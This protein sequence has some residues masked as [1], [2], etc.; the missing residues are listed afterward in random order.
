MKKYLFSL[1]FLSLSYVGFAQKGISYQAVILDPN[2]IEAPGV[3]IN[4]QP[5]INGD[6]WVKFSIY[7]SALQFEEVHKTKTDAY[8]LVNLMIGSV[9]ATSFNSLVWD[10]AQK[11][12]QVHVSFDQGVSYTKVS[13]QKLTY[14]PYS[15]YAETAS[16]LGGTL[17]I[18]GG[19][20]GATTLADA[21][22]NLGID[23]VDNTPDAAKPISA[24]MQA[25]LDLKANSGDV[26]TALTLKANTSDVNAGLALKADAADVN[27]S[28]AT[29]VDKEN[30]KGLSSNDYTT[31]EKNKLAA[32]SGIG[33]GSQGTTGPQGIQGLTGQPGAA[34]PQGP[35]GLTGP[36]GPAGNDGAAGASGTTGAT[37]AAGPTGLTGPAGATGPQGI[38]G[39][40]GPTGPTGNDGAAGPTGTTGAT[41]AA[42]PTGATGLTGPAGATGPQG[43]QGLT[44]A[45][46][47]QGIQGQT[48]ATG[49]APSGTGIVT[50]SNGTLQTP[51]ELTGDI[52]TSGAGL[53]T[54]IATGAVTS[55]KLLDGTIATADVA[56][57]AITD[58]KIDGV[59]GTKVSGNISGNEANVSGTVA[60]ANGGTGQT[61][62][63]GIQAVLGLAGTKVAIGADAGKTNQ[64]EGAF[65]FGGA[66][67][68]T[69]QGA[70][71]V[72]LGYVAGGS[73][74]GTRS[75]AIGVNAAQYTQGA[76]AVAIGDVAG[77][78]SQGSNSVA[79]GTNSST[80]ANAVAIGGYA[81]SSF[82][83]S[84]A[85]GYK[86][87]TTA[88]NTIQLGGDGVVTGSTAITNVK[89]TGTL[90]AGTV[91]YPNTH[92]STAGQVLTINSGGTATWS[93]PANS[94]GGVHTVGEN[95]GGGIVFYITAGGL[96]GLIADTYENGSASN[97]EALDI[98]TNPMYHNSTYGGNLYT[99]WRVP[100]YYE[101]TL[102]Y[103]A[104]ATANLNLT[105]GTYLSCTF[106][107]YSQY[108]NLKF[109]DKSI[110]LENA[111]W[112]PRTLRAI[113]SF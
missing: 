34:G 33:S 48:G 13:D 112:V 44:G 25:A 94:G 78:I 75:I 20:T 18:T 16:K 38:Q 23:K 35:I 90:T 62:I 37:G 85:I 43:I 100:T 21:R 41:G 1:I 3:D 24:A 59:A 102:L 67:G 12:L 89:T 111:N 68:Q 96:H 86:A 98:V 92:N 45:T 107:A 63:A 5:F 40:T 69:N 22:I 76:N 11:T 31:A 80:A 70:F 79:I 46:G 4:G 74:Q 77:Q 97:E 49:P 8:G 29:K 42:G 84:T 91:T 19:G 88:A 6:V 47:A 65:A 73:S 50:V 15:L 56:N 27:S 26:T 113:R 108:K 61:T 2:P 105:T 82:A 71:A 103:A 39:L 10:S 36:T 64:A 101:L 17:D 32:I 93:T 54:S 53:I 28:L 52:T 81:I 95:F 57:A 14:N 66:A 9:S 51:G 72:A 7:G 58:A 104:R 83:N 30:G 110:Q 55:D 109:S 87:A 60:V 99:D 106:N